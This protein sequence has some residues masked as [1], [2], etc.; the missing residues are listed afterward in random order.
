MLE[1][2]KKGCRFVSQVE[3]H[4]VREQSKEEGKGQ[5]WIQL[6]NTHDPGHGM[7][8][9][10]DIIQQENITYEGAKRSAL[11]QQ[12]TTRLQEIGMTGKT[13]QILLSASSNQERAILI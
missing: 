8:W 12:V 6:G 11:S 4:I 5:E 2:S 7:V 9:E 10:G 13:H 1:S 3:L